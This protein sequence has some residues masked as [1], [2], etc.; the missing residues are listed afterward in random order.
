MSVLCPPGRFCSFPRL[1]SVLAKSIFPAVSGTAPV[2]LP[3][4]VVLTGMVGL[5][6]GASELLLNSM[7]CS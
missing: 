3:G 2:P 5:V 4:L 1:H 7:K 6:F